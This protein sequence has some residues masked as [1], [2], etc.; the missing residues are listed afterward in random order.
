MKPAATKSLKILIIEDDLCTQITLQNQLSKA[1]LPISVTKTAV[2]LDLAFEILDE[3][4]FD[5]ILLDLNLPDSN[6]LDTLVTVTKRYPDIAIIVIAGESSDTLGLKAISIGAQEYLRKG[7]YTGEMLAK[8]IHYAIER[9]QTQIVLDRKQRNLEAI[10]DAAPV[11]MLLIDENIIVRRAND[12]IRQMTRK[13]YPQIINRKVCETLSCV[14]NRCPDKNPESNKLYGECLIQKT[15]VNVLDSWQPIH[16][17]EVQP[18]IEVGDKEITPWLRINTEPVI[19]DGCRHALMSINNITES[20]KA[21]E[22]L[23]ETTKI[24]SQFISIVSHELRT[25]LAAMKESITLVLDG[26]VGR[27]NKKQTKYL[28]IAKRN[29]DRLGA[30]INDVLDFQKLESCE[31]RLQIQNNDINEVV[32][33]VQET[34]TFAA[35]KK[36]INLLFDPAGDLPKAKFDPARSFRL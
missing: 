21:E 8:S 11:G 20:K 32:T 1:S 10:F 27:L 16:K 36:G 17:V 31:M 18:T 3:N 28:S 4:N 34:M 19:I 25:P 23:L 33:E 22:K 35:K 13:D 30:L 2:S 9:K 14:N 7:T 24:K 26:I 15:I 29:I 12:A 5:L 6:G